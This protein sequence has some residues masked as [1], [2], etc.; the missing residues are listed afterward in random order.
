M[1]PTGDQL[2]TEPMADRAKR[3][4]S[5]AFEKLVI[6]RRKTG[7]KLIIWRDGKI[8]HVPAIDVH[9]PSEESLES[10]GSIDSQYARRNLLERCNYS[11]PDSDTRPRNRLVIRQASSAVHVPQNAVKLSSNRSIRLKLHSP[12]LLFE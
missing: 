4:L 11:P 6:E 9:L 10:S 8:C 1:T 3:A 7:E 12:E 5:A 2:K